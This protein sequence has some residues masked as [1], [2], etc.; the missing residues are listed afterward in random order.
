MQVVLFCGGFGVRMKDYGDSNDNNHQKITLPKPLVKIGNRPIIWH[1]MK[2]Y[3]HFGFNDFILALGYEAESFKNYFLK[4]NE[5]LSNDFE[6]SNGGEKINV[7]N[8]DIKDWKIKFVD[9]GLYSNIGTR[10]YKLRKHIKSDVF[11]ANYTDGLTDLNL[12]K[13]LDFFNNNSKA[14]GSFI[15]VKPMLPFHSIDLNKNGIV[16]SINPP[17]KMKNFLINAGYFIFKKDIFNY[18]NEGEELVEE[19]LNRLA[20]ENKLISYEHDGF[21]KNIDNI[22][23]KEFI[24]KLYHSGKAPWVLWDSIK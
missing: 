23:D 12:N 8:H 11:F 9:T 19:P 5:W 21:W 16:N 1:I 24:D 20:N 13:Y 18:I 6:I 17:G 14:A 4:Y 15:S 2:Y 3:S 10:L 7:F 22:K